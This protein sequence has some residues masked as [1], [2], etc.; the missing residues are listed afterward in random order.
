MSRWREA[1]VCTLLAMIIWVAMIKNRDDKP[2]EGQVPVNLKAEEDGHVW[3]GFDALPFGEAFN[4]MYKKHGKGYVFEW[5]GKAYL[6]K[7]KQEG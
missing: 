4:R 6:T 7:Y 2:K 1:V 5:R 3:M